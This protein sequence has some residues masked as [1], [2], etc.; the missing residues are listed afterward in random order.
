MDN[1][2]IPHKDPK[3]V[4][5]VIKDIEEK[6]SKITVTRG[7]K[8]NFAGMDIVFKDEGTARI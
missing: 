5:S 3:V 2:K 7:K 1:T 6:F 4:D 8:H